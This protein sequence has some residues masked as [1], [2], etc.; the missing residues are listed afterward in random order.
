M[1]KSVLLTV[2]G[3]LI[4]GALVMALLKNRAATSAD[5]IESEAIPGAAGTAPVTAAGQA[6][7]G[8]AGSTTSPA[9][10]PARLPPPSAR[11]LQSLREM[12]RIVR[13]AVKPGA[14]MEDLIR[15]LQEGRQQP[16]VSRNGGAETGALMIVR[17][18][19]PPPGT[20]Y[21]TAQY[22]TDANGAKSLQHISFEFKPGSTSYEEAVKISREILG[23]P[24]E[25][26]GRFTK[27]NLPDN[28][29]HWINEPTVEQLIENPINPHT[30]EDAGTVVFAIEDEIH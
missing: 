18:K 10:A 13:D 12:A 15:V 27:W 30:K 7:L 8:A 21:F 2:A 11:E 20:R 26:R 14:R 22:F 16:F 3:G 28:R 19:N 29:I 5:G 24:A 17:T 4:A 23:A 1:K 9:P 6:S 25:V